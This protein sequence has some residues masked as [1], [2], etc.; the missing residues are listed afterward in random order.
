MA[1]GSIREM[2]LVGG[3]DVAREEG[4]EHLGDGGAVR[5]AEAWEATGGGHPS[6]FSNV[7][8]ESSKWRCHVVWNLAEMFRV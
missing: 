5:D 7:W 4:V 3:L 6:C 1:L 8:P 2:E